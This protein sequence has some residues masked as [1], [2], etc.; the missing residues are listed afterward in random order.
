MQINLLQLFGQAATVPT[1]T[2]P[3]VGGFAE[4]LLAASPPDWPPGAVGANPLAAIA[5]NGKEISLK[6]NAGETQL[7]PDSEA[8]PRADSFLSSLFGAVTPTVVTSSVSPSNG[9]PVKQTPVRSGNFPPITSGLWQ[10]LP[11]MPNLG[12]GSGAPLPN[13][14]SFSSF[15]VT[16][17]QVGVFPSFDLTNPNPLPNLPQI[18]FYQPIWGQLPAWTG[19]G[20]QNTSE[21]PLVAISGLTPVKAPHQTLDPEVLEGLGLA[22]IQGFS[23]PFEN[24]D[25]A[26]QVGGSTP[27]LQAVHFEESG[28]FKLESTNVAV[29]T[30]T[31][32]D[33]PVAGPQVLTKAVV[34]SPDIAPQAKEAFVQIIEGKRAQPL[35]VV[36]EAE[37]QVSTS[38]AVNVAAPQPARAESMKVQS[39][40]EKV[41]EDEFKAIATNSHSSVNVEKPIDESMNFVIEQEDSSDS[42]VI[43]DAQHSEPARFEGGHPAVAKAAETKSSIRADLAGELSPERRQ[44]VLDQTMDRLDRLAIHRPVS[45]MV[46]RLLPK[47]LGEI[48]LT[49]KSVG[50]RSDA[51]IEATDPRVAHA[52]QADQPRLTQFIESKGINLTSFSFQSS[53]QGRQEA[54][55]QQNSQKPVMILEQDRTST[56]PASYVSASSENLD[57]V[58]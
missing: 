16:L 18:D 30:A 14:P 4:F 49:I 51:K 57:L 6:P 24:G 29:Q 38:T 41:S 27:N 50:S 8:S 23:I 58:I 11:S 56:T 46:I 52:L 48:T 10:N 31:Q 53:E 32:E 42:V 13:L 34:E 55:P 35:Q 44:E 39:S 17:P 3:L 19:F 40:P 37:A 47:E 21:S 7:D 26:P 12:F 43:E 45:Q 33:G 2:Q 20:S 25:S 28:T 5:E 1:G 22:E 15:R 9:S 36:R 54:T